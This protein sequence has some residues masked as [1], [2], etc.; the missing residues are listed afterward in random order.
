MTQEKKVTLDY[1]RMEGIIRSNTIQV[2]ALAHLLIKKGI[3]T[4]EEFFESLMQ[5]VYEI[6]DKRIRNS[7]LV[8]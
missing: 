5:K 4:E 1:E 3:C 2:N 6:D 7:P 8:S